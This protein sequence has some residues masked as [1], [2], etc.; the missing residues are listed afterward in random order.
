MFSYPTGE[1]PSDLQG[2]ISFHRWMTYKSNTNGTVSVQ[3]YISPALQTAALTAICNVCESYIAAVGTIQ[4][5]TNAE[6]YNKAKTFVSPGSQLVRPNGIRSTISVKEG[7]VHDNFARRVLDGEIIMSDYERAEIEVIQLPGL[8]KHPADSIVNVRLSLRELIETGHVTVLTD[9]DLRT[10]YLKIPGVE[11]CIPWDSNNTVIYKRYVSDYDPEWVFPPEVTAQDVIAGF[12]AYEP[13]LT[14]LAT[15]VTAKA[16]KRSVDVLTAFAEMPKTIISVIN[17]FKTVAKVLRDAKKGD[18]KLSES[19]AKRAART[20]ARYKNRMR[21]L[22]R[23][24]SDPKTSKSRRKA[25]LFS[26]NREEITH[27]QTLIKTADEL[28]SASADLWLNYRYTIMPNVYLAQDVYSALAKYKDEWIRASGTTRNSRSISVAGHLVDVDEVVK[29][30]IKRSFSMQTASTGHTVMS[31]DIFV[32][33]WELVPLSFVY[34][35]FINFGDLLAS[36]SYNTDWEQQGCTYSIKLTV[37]SEIGNIDPSYSIEP[38]TVVK[39]SY[40]RRRVVNPND[41]CGLVWQPKLGL[42]R[43]LDLISLAWRPV[44][45]LLHNRK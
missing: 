17:G 32:T 25:L 3:G 2:H 43:Q 1:V 16:N 37:D 10:K 14:S 21:R 34:D 19:Y 29:F 30:L 38:K 20:T 40:Y 35:W 45:S 13:E 42:E 31:N 24:L 41:Y 23:E 27:R 18:I 11:A 36:Q 7:V 4:V 22:E 44:R 9:W 26:K 33:A 39:G 6:A 5:D 28:A 12:R 8:K 15:N